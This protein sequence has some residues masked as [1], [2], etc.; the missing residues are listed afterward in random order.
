MLS[1]HPLSWM[2]FSVFRVLTYR[3]QIPFHCSLG[4][5]V[6]LGSAG[7]LFAAHRIAQTFA[8]ALALWHTLSTPCV[9]RRDG[10]TCCSCRHFTPRSQTAATPRP[11]H[12]TSHLESFNTPCGE[13]TFDS[14]QSD[15]NDTT[16]TTHNITFRKHAG[17][18]NIRHDT[19]AWSQQTSYHI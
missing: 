17:T 9:F 12:T 4:V 11:P 16:A 3:W 19:T 10:D 2:T 5:C 18:D 13:V 14:T 6:V 7:A 15:S 8:V 1:L